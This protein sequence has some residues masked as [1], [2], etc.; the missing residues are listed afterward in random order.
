MN[1]FWPGSTVIDFSFHDGKKLN[2]SLCLLNTKERVP[3][4]LGEVYSDSDPRGKSYIISSRE[5]IVLRENFDDYIV[6]LTR[7]D[8]AVMSLLS[9]FFELDLIPS[10]VQDL[11]RS[12]DGCY[13]NEL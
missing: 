12:P 13:Y 2:L 8:F 5:F 9:S 6:N 7:D 1:Y 10:D 3:F 11:N 4:Y